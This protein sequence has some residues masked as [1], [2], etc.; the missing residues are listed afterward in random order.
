VTGFASTAAGRRALLAVAL[1][2]ALAVALVGQAGA[3][4]AA[5]RGVTTDTGQTLGRAGDAYLSGL[6][7]FA[8]ALLWNRLEPQFHGYYSGV[9][10]K[11]QRFLMPNLRLVLL[12]DPHFVQAYYDVPWILA[13]NKR[14]ADA[15]S[16][17]R[18]GVANNPRS[19]LL[20]MAYAQILF[21]K[22]KDIGDAVLQA[23]IALK[24]DMQ[25]RDPLE[26]WENVTIAEDI[27][28]HAGLTAK[29]DALLAILRGL[30][31][32]YGGAAAIPGQREK[33]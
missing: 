7:V 12:L 3:D 8:A 1:L 16:I 25:W 21:L 9:A 24:S 23:D 18:E 30:E 2:T 11:D 28:R 33:D 14:V 10:L 26:Y 17:A 32:K 27:Y 22:T 13:D 5:P 31:Q 4:R 19:G 29:A 15:L 6:R 20:R